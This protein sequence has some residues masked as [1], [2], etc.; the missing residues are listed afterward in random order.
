MLDRLERIVGAAPGYAELRLHRNVSRTLF[1]RKGALIQNSSATLAGAS[2]RC[3]ALGTFG[4]ASLPDESD[5]ALE[6]VLAEAR[7]NADLIGRRVAY[8][9]QPLP[10]T[11]PGTG[12]WDYRLLHA[13]LAFVVEPGGKC[14][15]EI[16]AETRRGI[17]ITRFS[18]GMPNDNLDFSGIAKNSFLIEDGRIKHPL[19]ETMISGNLRELL[20]DIRG[21]ARDGRFRQRAPADDGGDRRDDPRPLNLGPITAD[22]FHHCARNAR[23]VGP[24]QVRRHRSTTSAVPV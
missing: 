18:G 13:E 14:E 17:L 11:A 9:D 12:V 3:H 20:L 21:L 8:S 5:A 19:A 4:F 10:R 1:M 24:R 2:A 7:D 6:R 16:I 15:A 22:D 23:C